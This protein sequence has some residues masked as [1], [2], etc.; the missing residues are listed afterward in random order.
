M[1]KS[2]TLFVAAIVP[3]I[4]GVCTA[5]GGSAQSATTAQ[6]DDAAYCQALV[7]QYTTYIGSVGGSLGGNSEVG[8]RAA[9]DADVAI[10]QCRGGNP[11]PAIPVLEQ[12]LLDSHVDLPPRAI[13]SRHRPFRP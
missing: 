8:P 10:A 5:T 3:L 1:G 13:Y 7:N 2:A 11:G 6:L 9:A 4:A 12:K